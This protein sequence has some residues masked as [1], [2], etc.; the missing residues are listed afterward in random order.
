MQHFTTRTSAARQF[1]GATG[2][3]SSTYPEDYLAKSYNEGLR[4]MVARSNDKPAP[5]SPEHQ[6]ALLAEIK[7]LGKLMRME[8]EQKKELGAVYPD[9]LQ[10]KNPLIK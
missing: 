5:H 7:R 3:L 6:G 4:L 1:N 9:L 10:Y 2:N 8:W